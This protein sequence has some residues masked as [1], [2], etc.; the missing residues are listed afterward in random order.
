MSLFRSHWSVKVGEKKPSKW[1]YSG[2]PNTTKSRSPPVTRS[3]QNQKCRPQETATPSLTR[4][5]TQ[6]PVHEDVK[7][8]KISINKHIQSQ[9]NDS[10][11]SDYVVDDKRVNSVTLHKTSCNEES[12]YNSQITSDDNSTDSTQPNEYDWQAYWRNYSDKDDTEENKSQETD[13]SSVSSVSSPDSSSESSDSQENCDPDSEPIVTHL[14]GN[15][16]RTDQLFCII[17]FKVT[18]P[19]PYQSGGMF[20]PGWQG[21]VRGGGE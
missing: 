19:L 16:Y 21:H 7:P 11:D 2:I 12:Q 14:Q 17:N 20:R 15:I 13:N 1:G 6:V 3:F 18:L 4:S 9:D 8:Y 5:S 10:D